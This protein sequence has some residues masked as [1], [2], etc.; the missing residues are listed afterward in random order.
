MGDQTLN[1]SLSIIL[2]CIVPHLFLERC[3][4]LF[5]NS[6]CVAT[7]SLGLYFTVLVLSEESFELGDLVLI[8]LQ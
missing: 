4:E 7:L 2:D 8:L 3:I 5:S 1:D 6:C